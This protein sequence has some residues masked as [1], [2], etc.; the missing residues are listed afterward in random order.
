MIALEKVQNALEIIKDKIIRTPLVYSP[1]LSRTFNADIYLKLE[2]LQKTGSF[3]IR[4]ATFKIQSR[5]EN[6]PKGG[7]VTASAGNHAQGV[8]LS[9]RQAKLPA[10]IVM[11]EWA[12]ISKQ[13]ATIG[14]GGN[15]VIEGSNLGD[16]LDKAHELSRQ[17][18]MFIHPYDDS[19]VIT[20]QGTIGLE[21]LE[22]LKE[23]DIILV[24]VGGGG[25][26]SGISSTVHT[27]NPG[28]RVIGVQTA[29]CPAAY[30]SYRK[31]RMVRVDSRPSIAD[32]ISVKKIGRLNFDIILKH[33]DSIVL[34]DEDQIASAVLM[35]LEKKKILAEGAG[36]V[37]LAALLNGSVAI[38][39]GSRVVLVISGGNV[40]SPL[41]GRIIAQGL[42]K[43]KRLV[44]FKATIEDT[45]GSMAKLLSL[46]AEYKANVL[47]IYHARNVQNM[48]IYTAGVELEIETRGPEHMMEIFGKLKNAGYNIE[49]V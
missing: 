20:G 47:H 2:N 48:P 30:E 34:A 3:K 42:I 25:L 8:A 15:V 22:D 32:G 46:I 24:P 27:I 33:V 13:E 38:P 35:L 6:I 45:P 11:P 49:I 14:Y 18:M 26:I 9:A 31:K 17:G 43:N 41:L 7:V 21:I 10:T 1:T 28:I 12:S 23:P 19:D 29:S 37:S 4:G 36:A 5:L 44:R 40:D 16:S 39:K